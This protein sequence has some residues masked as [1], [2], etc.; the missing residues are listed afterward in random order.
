MTCVALR[1]SFAT[2]GV[3]P[4]ASLSTVTVAPLGALA[5]LISCDFPC[6]MLAQASTASAGGDG[7]FGKGDRL[8]ERRRSRPVER[9]QL[10]AQQPGLHVA[11]GIERGDRV[12]SQDVALT[13]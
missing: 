2:T 10:D 8:V 6:M 12:I 4:S 13:R 11:T 3:V 1:L 7:R 9:H 5:M